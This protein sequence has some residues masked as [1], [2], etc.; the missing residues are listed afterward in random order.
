M[1]A[2]EGFGERGVDGRR[3]LFDTGA[4]DD[5]VKRKPLRSWGPRHADD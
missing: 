2:D 5:T 3:I 4:D 1:L